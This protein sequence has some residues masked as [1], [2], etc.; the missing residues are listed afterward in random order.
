MSLK[1]FNVTVDLSELADLGPHAP[2]PR[3]HVFSVHD[4]KLHHILTECDMP[5]ISNFIAQLIIV[6]FVDITCLLEQIHFHLHRLIHQLL[7]FGLLDCVEFNIDIQLFT[8][9]PRVLNP[10]FLEPHSVSKAKL[11]DLMSVQFG[12]HFEN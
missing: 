2:F 8:I 6:H 4:I 3:F 10:W 9:C 1:S 5:P 7:K 11:V 12:D